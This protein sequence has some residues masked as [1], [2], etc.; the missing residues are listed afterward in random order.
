MLGA[1]R[2]QPRSYEKEQKVE[3]SDEKCLQGVGQGACVK[4]LRAKQQCPAMTLVHRENTR[5]LRWD[6]RN[7]PCCSRCCPREAPGCNST[8]IT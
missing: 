7:G 3:L 4:R 2:S 1:H 5:T 6:S 8:K